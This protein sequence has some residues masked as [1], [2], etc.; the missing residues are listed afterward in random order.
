MS[1]YCK[2][3]ARMSVELINKAVQEANIKLISE[4]VDKSDMKSRAK[5]LKAV[6]KDLGN[7]TGC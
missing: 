5:I 7:Y 6:I 2:T 4:K 3:C 1:S